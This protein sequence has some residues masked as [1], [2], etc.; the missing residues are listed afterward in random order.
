MTRQRLPIVVIGVGYVGRALA[1]DLVE[2]DYEVWGIRRQMDMPPG[3][4]PVAVDATDGEALREALAPLAR[5]PVDVCCL[6]A[7]DRGDEAGYRRAYLDVVAATGRALSSIRRFLFASSTAVYGDAAGGWV[8]E[9]TP[10]AP[11]RF[12]GEILVEAEASIRSIADETSA[13]RYGGIYG[14]TR[15]RTVRAVRLGRRIAA[16]PVRHGNRIHRDDCAGV[17]RHL[18]A[19]DTVEDVYAAV[20]DDPA[21]LAEV[22]RW[23]CEAL[24]RDPSGLVA[25]EDGPRGRGGDKRV[26]NLR[27]R[28]SGYVFRF[29]S[30]REGYASL[31]AAAGLR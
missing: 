15:D 9:A 31:I 5:R 11:T 2:A 4:R 17:M 23:L 28:Q 22:E 29:P 8:D 19:R 3:V 27:L 20:D 18:L 16:G 1:G 7:P 10:V 24:G 30:Y 21:P 26:R 14:P 6:T 12:S 25:P 13:V